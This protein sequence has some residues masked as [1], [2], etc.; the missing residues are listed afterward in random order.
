MMLSLSCAAA[1]NTGGT[2]TLDSLTPARQGTDLRVE[3]TLS[4]P[5]KPLVETAEKPDR[6]FLD[7]PDTLCNHTEDIA[8]HVN[9][10]RWVRS[11]Q[12]GNSPLITRVVLELDRL[13]SYNVTTEGNR[14]IVT[15]GAAE[16]VRTA[17]HAAPA[18]ATSGNLIGIFRKH[19]ETAPPGP[20][21]EDT[22]VPQPPATAQGPSFEPGSDTPTASL[23]SPQAPAPVPQK[24]PAVVAVAKPNP[25]TS[26]SEVTALGS[27][28]PAQAV[29]VDTPIGVTTDEPQPRFRSDT[30]AKR[31]PRDTS[32]DRSAR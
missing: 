27:P 30:R 21:D 25:V 13:H 8:L 6:I 3:I 17:S 2:A 12:H 19:R 24:L 18:S 29:P 1:Q 22:G 15:V 32:A 5:V 26:D 20:H 14:V 28:E 9:G 4:T 7:F 16:R 10:V 11:R 31:Y 23:P